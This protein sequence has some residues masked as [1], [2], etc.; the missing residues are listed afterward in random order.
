MSNIDI[1]I[2]AGPDAFTN[3]FDVKITFPTEVIPP[4]NIDV[5]N[6][7]S[8]R[9]SSFKI[10]DFNLQEYDIYYKAI[11]LKRFAP[12]INFARKLSLPI[13][14]D[15]GWE[16][17]EYLK[18]WKKLYMDES[19]SQLY[20]SHFLNSL[21]DT[22]YHGKIELFAY[23]T[24]DA[25]QDVVDVNNLGNN[26]IVPRWTFENVVCQ[27]VT[28]PRFTRD[29]ANVIELSVDFLFGRYIPPEKQT[30]RPTT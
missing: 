15:A 30:N 6:A 17:Y 28:E 18:K 8:V 22:Q 23:K 4:E 10:P 29:S 25:L 27:N 21:N 1:L 16:Y 11:K 2:D 19:I 20:F 9:T 7:F 24:T 3:L 26:V 12:K 13:R 5:I 14:I